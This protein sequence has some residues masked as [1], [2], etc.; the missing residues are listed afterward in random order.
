LEQVGAQGVVEYPKVIVTYYRSSPQYIMVALFV[1][2]ISELQY[3]WSSKHMWCVYI[4]Y[5]WYYNYFVDACTH[6][7]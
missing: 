4:Y 5:I 2:L 6:S 1:L 7:L 3:S